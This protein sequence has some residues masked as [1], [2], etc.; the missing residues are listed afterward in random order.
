[1]RITNITP[2]L[3]VDEIEGSLDFYQGRLGYEKVVEVPDGDRLGFVLLQRDGCEL[4]MQTRRSV[5]ADAPSAARELAEHSVVLYCDVDSLAEAV[6]ALEGT[7]VV[8]APRETS[9]GA[10]EIFVKDPAGFVI[11][12]ANS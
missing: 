8:V 3:I 6:R 12:P 9:Y 1:M 2:I 10:R 5:A 7:P 4:M 11:G